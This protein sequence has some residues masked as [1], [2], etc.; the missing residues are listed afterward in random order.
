[1][2]DMKDMLKS[3]GL[4]IDSEGIKDFGSDV[5]KKSADILKELEKRNVVANNLLFSFEDIEG[6]PLPPR[7]LDGTYFID[8]V[9]LD[10]I[11]YSGSKET[12]IRQGDLS[13]H[14]LQ[15]NIEKVGL[16]TPI[17]VV[18]FGKPINTDDGLPKY[19][20]YIILSGKRRYEAYRSLGRNSIPVLVD[21]TINNQLIDM[22]KGIIQNSRA[23]TFGE[24]VLYAN[25]MNLEQRAMSVETLENFVGYKSG[26][27]LKSM[28]I[29]QMKVDYPDIYQQVITEKLSIEQGFKRLEKEIEKAEKALLEGEDG[30][31]GDDVEDALRDK[32]NLGNLEL[33][34][35]T[36]TLGDRHILDAN[37]RR[38]VESR[39]LGTCQC[40]GFGEGEDDF[41]GGFNA[42][43]MI[44]VMYQGPDLKQNLILLCKNCHGF[45]H[46]YETAQFNPDQ[47]TYDKHE[48]VRR[49]VI[50]GNML[51][52]LRTKSIRDIKKAD[53]NTYNLLQKGS[54]SLG[55]AIVKSG[56]TV[57]GLD[58]FDNDPYQA[59]MDAIEQLNSSNENSLNALDDFSDDLYEEEDLPKDNHK[60]RNLTKEQI[61][62]MTKEEVRANDID[63]GL[64]SDENVDSDYLEKEHTITDVE[65]QLNNE[66]DETTNE[67][68]VIEEEFTEETFDNSDEQLENTEENTGEDLDV[69][70]LLEEDGDTTT[71]EEEPY[72]EEE[73][74]D[75]EKYK[76]D[77]DMLKFLSE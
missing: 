6:E 17:H 38:S 71:A 32:Q 66:V 12:Q 24:K 35:H 26:E 37:I 30:M 41:M 73:E 52:K 9:E 27:F 2:E 67:E 33:D 40:C 7:E 1:M 69:F 59:F 76:V 13:I 58:L 21:T 61:V 10:K 16:V 36:Q 68:T 57:G 42:H 56:I 8:M 23:Y 46:A 25:R 54:L 55:K 53:I 60:P 4:D 3:S 50:L 65:N 48:W 31:S 51:R 74:D 77:D 72:V 29:D 18:P 14:E 15:Q 39:D 28:Y 45:V 11:V 43:H 75:S 19:T 70:D 20:K 49:V 47:K 63:K 62:S 64:I 44:P 22:F 34:S 5:G